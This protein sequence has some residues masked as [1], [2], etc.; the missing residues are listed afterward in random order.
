MYAVMTQPRSG[1]AQVQQRAAPRLKCTA[2][3]LAVA[4]LVVVVTLTIGAAV[5]QPPDG[6]RVK[7][8][9]TDTAQPTDTAV[10]A[11]QKHRMRRPQLQPEHERAA[12]HGVATS[13]ARRQRRPNISRPPDWNRQAP[14]LVVRKPKPR[15]SCKSRE[16]W[17][18][19]CKWARDGAT[20]VVVASAGPDITTEGIGNAVLQHVG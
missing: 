7:R 18:A 20:R 3:R 9:R 2:R 8:H 10:V 16:E 4:A 14:L 6:T 1:G 13:V 17:Q 19:P 5:F 11:G 15:R 12:E